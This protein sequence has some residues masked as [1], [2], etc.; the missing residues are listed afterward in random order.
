MKN[1]IAFLLI[2]C[3]LGVLVIYILVISI[4]MPVMTKTALPKVFI[5][6]PVVKEKSGKGKTENSNPKEEPIPDSLVAKSSK[7]GLK[8]IFDLRKK[9]NWL[10]SRFELASEDSMYLVLDLAHNTAV[11]EM[12]GIVLH[13]CKIVKSEVSNSIKMFRNETFLLN[14]MAEP[15]TVKHIDSTIPKISFIEKIA[16][17]DTIEANKVEVEPKLPELEDVYIIL[18]FDRNIRLVIQ[19][20][21]KPTEKGKK[22]ISDLSWKYQLAEIKRT[23]Q[24]LTK[25]NRQ[26]SMPQ[27]TITLPKSDA[28]ILYKSLP[29]NI[30]MILRI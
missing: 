2:T 10:Q 7:D 21:E 28:T 20:N 12:K 18:D 5:N 24:S 8:D 16:P 23:V 25:F 14:W 4:V 6:A 22:A 27:I 29:V 30:K 17:K 13:E 9:E 11:I 3:I 26:P 15:F 1:K 19:Q